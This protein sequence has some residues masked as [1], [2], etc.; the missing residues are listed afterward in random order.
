MLIV[1]SNPLL[2]TLCLPIA[3]AVLAFG[4]ALLLKS[5]SQ[6]KISDR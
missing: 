5:D 1:V 4:I 2:L 6:N 3:T